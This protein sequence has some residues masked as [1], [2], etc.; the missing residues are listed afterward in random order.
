MLLLLCHFGIFQT[1]SE[2]GGILFS[3][4]WE[5]KLLRLPKLKVFAASLLH[6]LI[7]PLWADQ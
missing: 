5:M 2:S 7:L 4:V 6:L 3:G 1:H